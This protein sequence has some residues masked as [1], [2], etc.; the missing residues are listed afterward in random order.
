MTRRMRVILGS[1]I[2]IGLV[3]FALDRLVWGYAPERES[4]VVRR[5]GLI[6]VPLF[7]SAAGTRRLRQRIIEALLP[8]GDERAAG[9]HGQARAKQRQIVLHVRVLAQPV[10]Q[11]RGS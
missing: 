1:V 8:D 5:T 3:G 6:G 4:D 9:R 7:G 10:W 11:S 2:A